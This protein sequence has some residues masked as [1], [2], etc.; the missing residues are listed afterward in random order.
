MACTAQS[1]TCPTCV[2]A[3][4]RR[5]GWFLPGEA[6]RAAD[7]LGMSLAELFRQRLTA[8]FWYEDA[9]I[10]TTTFVL[11]PLVGGQ[12]PGT[13]TTLNGFRG[14]CTFL[15][16]DNRCEIHAAKPFEC[17]Q[18]YCGM[19]KEELPVQHVDVAR[20]WT[21]HQSQ[22]AELLGHDPEPPPVTLFDVVDFLCA[23]LEVPGL[24]DYGRCPECGEPLI[25]DPVTGEVDFHSD[26]RGR[27]IHPD[28]C[29]SCK[30]AP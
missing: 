26:A 7:L 18:W 23:E 1:G 10:A 6:E 16:D 4:T 2:S 11:S 15:T 13:E 27:D 24:F 19:T 17:A 25:A 8:D 20:A 14:R 12:K 9:Q 30:E 3:C 5:P 29:R 21:D 28:C 22:I